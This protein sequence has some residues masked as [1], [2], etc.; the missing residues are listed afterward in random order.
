MT[1]WTLLIF[2]L[3]C[4]GHAEL[5]ITLLNRLHALPFQPKTFDRLRDV[6]RVAIIGFPLAMLWFV[7]IAGPAVFV[8]RY[9]SGLPAV[10]FVPMVLSGI[11]LLGI[12]VSVLTWWLRT[13]PSMRRADSRRFVSLPSP[14]DD[15]LHQLHADHPR[16][17]ELR[18][19]E[20]LKHVPFNGQFHL[21]INEKTLTPLGW[22][23]AL[24]GL[25]ILHISDWH[26]CPIYHRDFFIQAARAAAEVRADLV[27]FTGDLLDDVGCLNWLP[28]SLGT[29]SAPLGMYFIL[30]NHDSWLD[31]LP[32]RRAMTDLGWQDLGSRSAVIDAGGWPLLLAGDETPW[33]GNRPD[34]QLGREKLARV[35]LSHSPDSFPWAAGHSVDVTLAGHNHGG[36]IIIPGVGPIYSPSLFG[37][38]YPAGI[39]SHIGS[40]MH[41]S[42]GL[43]GRHPLRIGASPEMTRLTIRSPL[44]DASQD[45][46]ARRQSETTP[47]ELVSER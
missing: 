10:W 37:C 39:Y 5:W 2:L 25:S 13:R 22:P 1:A 33:F 8:E 28:E 17:R 43:A 40:W 45:S 23:A 7:G 11:G 35:L 19:L 6:H 16:N 27:A 29:L 18:G 38:R 4:A 47:Q 31:D 34:L 24:D 14:P 21:E 32:I 20:R 9:G 30:G 41:V 3:A 42:R 26:Y 46:L 12:A 44:A 15:L 36:Q